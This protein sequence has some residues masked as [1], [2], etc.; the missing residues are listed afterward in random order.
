MNISKNQ[1]YLKYKN[2]VDCNN[3][4]G[5]NL[6]ERICANLSFQKSDSILTQVY[7][8]LLWISKTNTID[9]L[10]DKLIR[11]QKTWRTFR[12]Q[13]CKIIYDSY[14]GCGGC[15]IRAIS[16]LF[17]LREL[18]DNRIVELRIWKSHYPNKKSPN[19]C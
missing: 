1:D 16:Y 6:S 3:K 19:H 5:D 9:S 11:L 15:H 17:C 12:D 13:H 2:Q 4:A 14:A 18:T 10:T 8:S 7:D